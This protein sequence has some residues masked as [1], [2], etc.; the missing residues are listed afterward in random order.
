M[1]NKEIQKLNKN[2]KVYRILIRESLTDLFQIE[3]LFE[4]TPEYIVELMNEKSKGK[5]MILSNFIQGKLCKEQLKQFY[6]EKVRL[7]NE[8]PM[9]LN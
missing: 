1:V 7:K 6:A 3:G 2:V 9:A 8:I 4:A 5:E